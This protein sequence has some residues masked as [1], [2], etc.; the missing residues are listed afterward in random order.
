MGSAPALDCFV[1]MPIG[2]QETEA[3]WKA[4][5]APTIASCGCKPLRIDQE[6]D[7][8]LLISQITNFLQMAPILVADLTFARPNCYFEI[9]FA[10]GLNKEKRMILC[11][12]EDHNAD[13]PNFAK[14][15]KV[16]FDLQSYGIVWWD[17]SQ[18]Q[19]FADAL[20][21]KLQQRKAALGQAQMLG[22]TV[23]TDLDEE[24]RRLTKREEKDA[25]P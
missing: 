19:V 21:V 6:D 3:I 2:R 23:T 16:H 9:G 1:I 13:S 4:V 10:M 18:P 24:L 20:T 14:S 5:Y 8:G 17:A 11:C 7:G 22:G 15:N 12:R 25:L